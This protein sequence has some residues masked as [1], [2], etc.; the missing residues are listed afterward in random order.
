M[1]TFPFTP[2]VEKLPA[3][4]P[5]IGP[6][7]FERETGRVFKARVGANESAFGISP[8]AQQAMIDAIDSVGWYNDPENYDL[9][10]ALAQE[11]NVS[12]DEIGVGGGIDDLLGLV[13]RAVLEPG[14][15]TVASTG[16]YPTYHYHIAGFDAISH[17]VPYRGDRNDLDA[18]IDAVHKTGSHLV[19]LATPDNPTGTW[20]TA[21]EQQAFIDALPDNCICIL[22]EA[23]FEFAPDEAV[24]PIHPHDPRVIRMRTFS[25]AHG[26]AGARVGYAIAHPEIVTAFDKIRLH[27]NVN[28]IAQ[29]GALVSLGD[30][31]F[32]RSVVD[33]VAEG[34]CEY[35]AL[36]R[37]LDLPTLPSATNFVAFDCGTPERAQ[38]ILDALI[39]RGVFVRKP[40]VP[41]LD[42][43]VRVTVGTLEERAIFAE[44]FTKVISQNR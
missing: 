38:H 36:G 15:V 24:L 12:V 20:H 31:A 14:Q 34:R 27:F 23:Y 35:D 18:L 26:M 29:I 22:D 40:A 30:H 32:I 21:V 5:F 16:S 11:Y 39:E 8:R 13:V 25:K 3:T 10:L 44:A 37:D 4:I 42:R 1:N 43:L 33:Q 2:L 6:E 28:R 7:T 17:T 9:R 19:Y 41:P